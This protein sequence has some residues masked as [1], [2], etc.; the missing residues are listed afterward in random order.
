[1]TASGRAVSCVVPNCRP[2]PGPMAYFSGR[3]D[4]TPRMAR[5]AA[6]GP[7]LSC[8]PSTE[9]GA[10]APRSRTI[11]GRCSTLV[12][13]T[14]GWRTAGAPTPAEEAAQDD[15]GRSS[16]PNGGGRRWRLEVGGGGSGGGVGQRRDCE[17]R[18]RRLKIGGAGTVGAW[19]SSGTR[20]GGSDDWIGSR[21][22]CGEGMGSWGLGR[23]RKEGSRRQVE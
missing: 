17:G 23:N 22:G 4:T 12:E 7:A 18:R 16:G 13:V 15:A 3:A 2:K 1:M 10:G 21:G 20:R 11:R 9:V 5:W 6:A 19:G 8:A 14:P